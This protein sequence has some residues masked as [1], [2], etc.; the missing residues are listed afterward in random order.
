MI[1]RDNSAILQTGPCADSQYLC[2]S[3]GISSTDHRG[4]YS[5]LQMSA[6]STQRKTVSFRKL[7]NIEL[8]ECCKDITSTTAN[9]S[10]DNAVE[11]FVE[12]YN[13][14]MRKLLDK[15]APLQTKE[16]VLR[17]NAPWYSDDLRVAKRERRKA[18]RVWRRTNLTIHRDIHKETCRGY[19]K[20]LTQSKQ[21]YYSRKITEC[22][23]DS[24]RLYSLTNRLLGK[25]QEPSLP[26]IDCDTELSNKF[27]AFFVGK[28]QSIR[29][30]LQDA[31]QASDMESDVLRADVRLSGQPLTDFTAA[32]CEEVRKLLMSSPSKS[33]EFDPIQTF[34]LKQCI[35]SFVPAIT[36]IVNKS[37]CEAVV[38]SDFKQAIVRPL[39]KKPGLDI[40]RCLRT[41]APSQIFLL[42]KKL[43][44]KSLQRE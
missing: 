36:T 15:H 30:L 27:A 40:R 18:E 31:N 6:N 12:V 14:D 8:T 3:R 16:I 7:Q 24:K 22:G 39:L 5:S 41:I 42:C 43:S 19:S 2:D 33:C 4:I 17:P 44:K 37:L 23:S 25:N 10:G 32:S 38:P 35:D 21:E 28:I 26:N 13:N 1:T 34:L 11:Q 29:T 20:L 9:I